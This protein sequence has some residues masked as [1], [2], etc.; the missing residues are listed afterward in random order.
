VTIPKRVTT[1]FENEPNELWGMTKNI[2]AIDH[3]TKNIR[4]IVAN[5]GITAAGSKKVSYSRLG[6]IVI[7]RTDADSSG[8]ACF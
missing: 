6:L 5:K 2:R 4:A 7:C 3:M 8:M 1:A